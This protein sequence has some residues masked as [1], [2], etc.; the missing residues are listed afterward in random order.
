MFN[1]AAAFNQPLAFDTSSVTNMG[2]MFYEA[3]AFN[4]PLLNFDATSLKDAACMFEGAAAFNQREQSGTL[5]PGR[6]PCLIRKGQRECAHAA[7]F[8]EISHSAPTQLR[9][10]LKH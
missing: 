9:P 8:L 7:Q 6:R 1:S 3:V 10:T 2:G 4:Q 5:S